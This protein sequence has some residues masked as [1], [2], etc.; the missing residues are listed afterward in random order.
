[1]QACDCWFRK[2]YS[3]VEVEMSFR[4]SAAESLSSL[5]SED[6]LMSDVLDKR[7]LE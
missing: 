3:C 7:D 5:P 4:L 2:S 1:M 6:D